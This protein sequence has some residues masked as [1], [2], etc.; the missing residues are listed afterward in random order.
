MELSEKL[1]LTQLLALLALFFS[2]TTLKAI[3]LFAL[4]C[5]AVFL[6]VKKDF[7]DDTVLK[8]R[9]WS[10]AQGIALSILIGMILGCY[11]GL[12]GPGTGT[13]MIMAFTAVQLLM[14]RMREPSLDYRIVHTQT[15]L[16]ERESTDFSL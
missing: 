8:K 7:G 9:E 11:D 6:T 2:E 14:S 13:F 10:A 16:I 1:S 12:I 3:I 15:D 4:P 5:A